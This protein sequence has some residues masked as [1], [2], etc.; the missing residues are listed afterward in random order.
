MTGF[1]TPRTLVIA[2]NW[3]G[4]AV[5]A[6]PL[7]R[8]LKQQ[9]PER[10]IDV[11]APAWVAPV[12]RAMQEVD[13]VL[14]TPFKH[15]ALQL[16]ERWRFARELKKRGYAE[17]YV[18]PNTLKFA[19]IPWLAG[20]ARRV[21][22]KGESRYG[23]INV[24]HRDDP[25][26]PRAMVPFYAALASPPSAQLPVGLPRPALNVGADKITSVLNKLG[27]RQDRLLLAFAPGAEFGNAKRWP[28]SHFS[29][30]A[31][32]VWEEH[33]DAQIILLGSGK[34]RAVCEEIS[35]LSPAIR[36]LA[37]DTSLD[38][39]VALIAQASAVVSNDSGLLHIASA[40]NR[41][42]IAIYGPTDPDHAP[43]FSDVARSLSLRLSCA[44]C[45]QRECPLGH[46]DCMQ[47]LSSD[48]VWQELQLML[49]I[50]RM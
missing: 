31:N 45:K 42:V 37:G 39:A 22:Y 32:T 6:Q 33:P 46:H 50:T 4:D 8:L 41:P 15:G 11:L 43:P 14:S 17:A 38:E 34:D 21:G 3:I 13:T 12:L 36:S 10:P 25:A 7:L 16:R 44:P 28:T 29:Q 18:L 5:M 19:L 20:I 47:K 1:C 49:P 24:M 40:L 27:L 26:H 2:P 9:H 35:A 48:L 30:L 23:L